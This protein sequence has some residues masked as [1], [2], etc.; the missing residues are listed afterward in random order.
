MIHY[1]MSF[2]DY[3][4]LPGWNWSLIKLL[5]DGSPKHVKYAMNAP[6]K[7][8]ASRVVL[9]AIHCMI[10]EPHN[11]NASFSTYAG[12]RRGAKYDAHCAANPPGTSV[13]N[14]R[15]ADQVW[16]TSEAV[17]ANPQV[18]KLL[19]D[20]KPDEF[21]WQGYPEVVLTWTD[22]ATGLPCKCRID[23]LGAALIDLKTLGTTETR[24]VNQMINRMLIHG[25][26]AHYHEGLLAHD[27]DVPAFLI[28][29]EGKGAQDVAVWEVDD[30]A[31]DGA[32]HVGKVIR[33]ELMEK[34]AK[35]VADDHWPGRHE[36]IQTTCLPDYGLLDTD[37]SF[38]DEV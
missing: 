5:K 15:E 34:L 3:R 18:Q 16:A 28:I 29:A 33:A 26:L 13:L 21:G 24:A 25:Q 12:T 31:P 10:L 23:W 7:D 2:E 19:G 1:D 4:A 32:L 20:G 36:A 14:L 22:D 35:C 27:I 30:G 11:F 37:F 38:N 6:D 8:T 17:L 9:R